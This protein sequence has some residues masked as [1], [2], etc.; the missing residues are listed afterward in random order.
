MNNRQLDQ[1]ILNVLR[2][3]GETYG[4]PLHT[5]IEANVNGFISLGAMYA[6]LDRLER[7]GLVSSKMGEATIERGN[8]RKKYFKIEGE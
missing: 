2:E 1:T 3:M 5:A 8:R 6:S 4:V 7:Q